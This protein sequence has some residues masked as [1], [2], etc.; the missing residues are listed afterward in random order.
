MT[1]ISEENGPVARAW[2]GRQPQLLWNRDEVRA[3]CLCAYL[4]G[5]RDYR[6]QR[7]VTPQEA[8]AEILDAD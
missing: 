1:P 7:R 4:A 2:H 8:V 6:E 5:E 3:L